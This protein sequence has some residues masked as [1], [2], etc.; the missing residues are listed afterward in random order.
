MFPLWFLTW[1]KNNRVVYAV[2]NGES[3]KVVS[4]LPVDMKAF[5]LG[6][7][8]FTAILFLILELLFQP[9]PLITSLVSLVVGILMA[10]SI[11]NSTRQIFEKETHANDKGW[12]IK[13][14]PVI[15]EKGSV[16]KKPDKNV[17]DFIGKHLTTFLFAAVILVSVFFNTDAIGM[18]FV[19]RLIAV[20]AVLF[21]AN[22]L[23]KILGWQRSISHRQPTAA[24]LL[25][26]AAVILNTAIVFI[27]PVNDAWY[28]MGDAVCILILIIASTIMLQIYNISTTRPLPKLF[29]RK[30]VQ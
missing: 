24:I 22:S 29:D 10:A 25:V 1:R 14:D 7:T 23:W 27:S 19:A 17:S 11:R 26:T 6:C 16:T 5:A 3:G 21:L 15:T 20:G 9:T 18:P 30:E 2:V 4:D 12:T 8:G 13:K 28:Y